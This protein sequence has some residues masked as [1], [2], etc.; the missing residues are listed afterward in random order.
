M[1]YTDYD[2]IYRDPSVFNGLKLI[3]SKLGIDAN[4]IFLRAQTSRQHQNQTTPQYQQWPSYQRPPRI[5]HTQ[6][7]LTQPSSR[8]LAIQGIAARDGVVSF[9]KGGPTQTFGNFVPCPNGITV[10]GQRFT[11]AEGAF[12]YRKYQ[13]SGAPQQE[14]NRFIF[15]SGEEAFSINRDLQQKNYR[16]P[17]NSETIDQTGNSLRDHTMY[18]VLR[19]KF[20]QNPSML[21]ELKATGNSFLLETNPGVGQDSY[22]AYRFDPTQPQFPGRGDNR[23]GVLLMYLRD[24]NPAYLTEKSHMQQLTLTHGQ[25][26]Q[27]AYR[28]S[29]YAAHS[30]LSTITQNPF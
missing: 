4:T 7:P 12:Q 15:A 27:E 21:E 20:T 11:T 18:E 29:R 24:S 22:W 26:I 6:A 13:L 19:A 14:L 10:F 2:S 23:L 9:Y 3:S 8:A 5:Q 30:Y 1:N 28:D 25:R 16:L 17:P